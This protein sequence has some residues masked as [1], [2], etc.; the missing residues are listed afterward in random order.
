[1]GT[2][3]QE[4]QDAQ[5]C[6]QRLCDFLRAIQPHCPAGTLWHFL[7]PE[8]ALTRVPTDADSLRLN[9]LS[10]GNG[11]SRGVAPQARYPAVGFSVLFMTAKRGGASLIVSL[12]Q[13]DEGT[14]NHLRLSFPFNGEAAQLWSEPTRVEALF[15]TCIHFWQADGATVDHTDIRDEDVGHPQPVYWFVH[16]RAWQQPLPPLPAGVQVKPLEEG[17]GQYIITTPDR[18]NRLIDAHRE[19][20]EAVKCILQQAQLYPPSAHFL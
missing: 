18:Y 13:G 15:T 9:A 7:G 10:P 8:D 3:N 17:A 5:S 12:G 6:A 4:G 11:D 1:M 2:P 16:E 19:A 20:S 14:H